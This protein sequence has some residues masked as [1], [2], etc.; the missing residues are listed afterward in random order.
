MASRP[1]TDDG[2]VA[3]AL[4]LLMAYR[5][6]GSV[7]VQDNT[8]YQEALR[9]VVDFPTYEENIAESER[10]IQGLVA[11]ANLFVEALSVSSGDRGD[12]IVQMYRYQND[13]RIY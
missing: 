2:N 6:D 3:R 12:D 10:Y 4:D 13:Q 11:L 9:Q 7:P 1:N 5:S 8:G